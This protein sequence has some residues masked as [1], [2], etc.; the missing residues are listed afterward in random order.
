MAFYGRAWHTTSQANLESY[1]LRVPRLR[2]EVTRPERE[3][4]T[5]ARVRHAL[6]GRPNLLELG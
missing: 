1:G 2:W 5:V 3:A 6:V 4:Q